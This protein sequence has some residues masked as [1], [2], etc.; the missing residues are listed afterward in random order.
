LWSYFQQRVQATDYSAPPTSGIQTPMT[1]WTQTP[2][3][4]SLIGV[5]VIADAIGYADSASEP[6]GNLLN[7]LSIKLN[8]ATPSAASPAAPVADYIAVNYP[9]TSLQTV[10]T[11]VTQLSQLGLGIGF[12][13]GVDVTYSAGSG[14][15]PVGTVNLSYPRRGRTVAQNGLTID[16]TTAR[17]YEFPE[18]GSQ[19]AN[20][21]YELGGSSAIVV[22][23]NAPSLAQGFPIWERVFSRA[24]AQSQ[25]IISL[26]SQTGLSDLAMYAYAA[27]APT[28]VLSATDPNL[29]LGSF[30]VGDDVLVT[31]PQNAN[32]GALFDPRFPA[33]LSQEF[34]IV[35]W[36]CDLKDEGDATVVLTLNQ[37]PATQ[38]L[39]PTI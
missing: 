28:V 11:I 29:P 5:Q 9:F 38:F 37:P 27:V 15:A 10:D 7:G 20:Q 25:N 17:G 32:D 33:G 3:D 31:M 2:W 26:L 22:D 19:T 23:Q 24:N 8:G 12:D 21:C 39:A 16:L 13:F 18:D 4:A 1:Y 6:Y 36:A 35:Q 34:R 30:I 14:S